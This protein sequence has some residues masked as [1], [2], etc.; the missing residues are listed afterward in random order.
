MA[1]MAI[2]LTIVALPSALSR[3]IMVCYSASNS[4]I[5][6]FDQCSNERQ[7]PLWSCVWHSHQLKVCIS[8]YRHPSRQQELLVE[9]TLSLVRP[10]AQHRLTS[11]TQHRSHR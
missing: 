11:S 7:E 8:P 3:V 2:S 10:P 9:A 6:N 1:M 4:V 5:A